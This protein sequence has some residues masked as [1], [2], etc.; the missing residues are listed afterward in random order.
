M[1]QFLLALFLYLII[2]L[3]FTMFEDLLLNQRTAIVDEVATEG[4]GGVTEE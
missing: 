1:Y 2:G 4:T 3:F